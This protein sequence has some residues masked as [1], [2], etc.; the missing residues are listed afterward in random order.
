MRIEMLAWKAIFSASKD[1]RVI[2]GDY[3]IRSPN[4]AENVIAPDAN[5]KIRYTIENQVF[6]VRGHSKRLE[7]LTAQHKRL[8]TTLVGSAHYMQP[9]FSWG[10]SEILNCSAGIKE[11]RESTTMIAVDSNHHINIV[12]A[13][14]L[15]HQRT[16]IPSL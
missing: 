7:P 6:I 15:E 2:F 3:L 13:E 4:A 1:R 5:G 14:I 10:D 8:A 11:I 16:R 9:S 12:I